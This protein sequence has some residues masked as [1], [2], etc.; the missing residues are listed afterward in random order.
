MPDDDASWLA[1]VA[2]SLGRQ[3]KPSPEPPESGGIPNSDFLLPFSLVRGSRGYIE[4][5]C[6]QINGCYERGYYDGCAVMCRR[7]LET[8]IIESFEKHGLASKIKDGGGEFLYLADL[9]DRTLH[10]TSW[11]LT[12]NA[13]RALPR[14]KDLGDKSAHSRRYN[15]HRAD[16]DKV[17][18]D[19]RFVVQ[20]LVYLAGL[21]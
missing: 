19:L 14:L 11:N 13:K 16:L 7:M 8:L 17:S 21:K 9:I 5:V 20:E 10:E 12:R 15:A 6:N 2:Q 18:D 3:F 1:A 4:Q